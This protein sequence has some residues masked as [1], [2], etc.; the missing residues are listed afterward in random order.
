M[1]YHKGPVIC[2]LTDSDGNM[3]DLKSSC[4]VKYTEYRDVY[5]RL[6]LLIQGY[7]VYER[8]GILR[9]SPIPFYMKQPVSIPH[10][11]RCPVSWYLRFFGYYIRLKECKDGQIS[12][13][14]KIR[15]QSGISSNPCFCLPGKIQF[16][17]KTSKL[18]AETVQ[19]CAVADGT[20]RIYTD[21]DEETQYGVAGIRAPDSVSYYDVYVN[22]LLLPKI[23]YQLSEGEL[24]F[25]TEDVPGK[26]QPVIIVFVTIRSLNQTILYAEE[27]QYNV[28]FQSGKLIYTN[29]D[30]L[31]EYGADGILDPA[32]V[33]NMN[34]YINAVLQPESNYRV[35][36]GTLELTMTDEPIEGSMMILKSLIL[37][38]ECMELL[39]MS[40]FRYNAYWDGQEKKYTNTDKIKM[41]SSKNIKDSSNVSYQHLYVN[42]VMQP[43]CNYSAKE[44][45]LSMLCNDSSIQSAPII[46][47]SYVVNTFTFLSG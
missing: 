18:T 26:G 1:Y 45:E 43:Y 21:E 27:H 9:S 15:L 42:G 13:N 28:A 33:S 22:G 19:Y 4:P 38:G 31:T 32:A 34:L 30:E 5:G 8:K 17:C 23:D 20:K 14:I 25:L 16:T 3:Q 24:E 40:E 12:A 41:Y 37:R 36:K 7:I 29:E 35:S 39:K 2:Y 44:N 46:L 11:Y 6:I 47:K 10:G